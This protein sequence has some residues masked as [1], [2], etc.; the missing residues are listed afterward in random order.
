[1]SEQNENLW[2][3]PDATKHPTDCKIITDEELKEAVI[4]LWPTQGGV[5]HIPFT[6]SSIPY[7][8]QSFSGAV[9]N[10][11][12]NDLQP[13]DTKTDPNYQAQ[14]K[15]NIKMGLEKWA[16][17]SKGKIEFHE[18]NVGLH[19]PGI[20]FYFADDETL[21]KQKIAAYTQLKLDNNGDLNQVAV[22]FPRA[23]SFW[24]LAE[25]DDWDRAD[26]VNTIT[27]ELGHAI[28]SEHF[29]EYPEM[30][31]KLMN[32][33]N[34]VFCSVMPY[35]SKI[36]TQ[37]NK[38]SSKCNPP[39]AANP[40][41]LDERFIQVNYQDKSSNCK[42]INST[43]LAANNLHA[44][45]ESSVI[46]GMH[47]GISTF[48]ANLSIKPDEPIFSN[49]SAHMI[50]DGALL[51]AIIYLEFPIY[52][53][54]AFTASAATKY[55]SD[56]FLK[57]LP[58]PLHS[59]LISNYSSFALN[60]SLGL[61]EG[62]SLYPLLTTLL[63]RTAGSMIGTAFGSTIGHFNAFLI[64]KISQAVYA[65]WPFQLPQM[66]NQMIIPT[67]LNEITIHQAQKLIVANESGEDIPQSNE[68]GFF[69]SIYTFFNENIKNPI[70]NRLA[71][72]EREE[73][74][75]DLKMT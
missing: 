68:P 50:A 33:E 65:H 32:M 27:H 49:K 15:E 7:W 71:F 19:S 75:Y 9:S 47:T 46:S 28:G 23:P 64:N 38:C 16:E 40:G 44:F 39:F 45:L 30:K 60:L 73:E 17:A 69:S 24:N 10:Y 35:F 57:L 14:V 52:T 12:R 63:S 26:N 56:N 8:S 13:L 66:E 53:T 1:M 67:E 37:Q 41:P 5:A 72:G 62:L 25:Q 4:S 3:F 54:A 22:V 34:G 61:Y 2:S 59:L 31:T 70:Q 43:A 21:A 48:A 20:S 58:S 18:A 74:K 51:A 11:L 29:H 42:R 55:L 6:F 36:R